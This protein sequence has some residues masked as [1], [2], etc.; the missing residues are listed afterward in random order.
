MFKYNDTN[1]DYCELV[2]EESEDDYW[3]NVQEGF[4]SCP[5]SSDRV[6]FVWVFGDEESYGIEGPWGDSIFWKIVEEEEFFESYYNGGQSLVEEE[7]VLDDEVI[8]VEV[9]E[10]EEV[11]EVVEVEEDTIQYEDYSDLIVT[12]T[13]DILEFY[14]IGDE[15]DLMQITY[16][17]TVDFETFDYYDYNGAYCVLYPNW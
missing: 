16:I 14:G 9:E 2:Y 13:Y 4:S 17:V 3:F 8:E 7:E 5:Y 10:V 6:Q 11:E 1:G 15:S 12:P